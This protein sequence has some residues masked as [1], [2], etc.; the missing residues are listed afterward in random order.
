MNRSR[1]WVHPDSHIAEGVNIGPN[2]TIYGDVE[3]GSGTWIG[4]NTVIM[5]GARIGQNCKV[6]PGAII[7]G[8]PQDLKY[9][10]E[11]TTVEIGDN[12][13][14]REFV[15]VNRG[16]SDRMKTTV[17][18]GCLLMAYVHVA[19]DC[20]IGNNCI[21]ANASTLAGHVVL[22][23]HI[24]L[25]G[26]VAI[27]QFV[28]IG[29]Y[30]FIAGTS[31]VRKDVPP[32]I[33]AARDPLGYAGI[34]AIGLKRKGFNNEEIRQIE[35]IYRLLYVIHSNNK[36]GIAAINKTIPDSEYK[37]TIMDFINNSENG[38]IRGPIG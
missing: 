20:I 9:A 25:E 29:K 13:V 24:T 26:M 38:I 17:G 3:I 32:Y 19:H 34:N 8:I 33:K 7:A 2:A 1:A 6:F 28:H 21:I 5:D 35:D 14:I 12:T 30:S 10:G 36:K 16:T 4:P 27:Q 37:S 23:D 31:K 18:S 11:N 15:T 22:A